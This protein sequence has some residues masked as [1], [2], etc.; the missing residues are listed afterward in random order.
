V[1]LLINRDQRIL[2]LKLQPKASATRVPTL[3]WAL[4]DARAKAD[5]ACAARRQLWWSASS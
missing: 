3:Q 1:E 2:P 4:D 5:P